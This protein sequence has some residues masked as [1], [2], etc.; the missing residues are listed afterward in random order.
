MYANVIHFCKSQTVIIHHTLSV[1]SACNLYT[2]DGTYKLPKRL[3][4]FNVSLASVNL[5]LMNDQAS[6]T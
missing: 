4:I 3:Y 5:E 6:I 1:L 2:E